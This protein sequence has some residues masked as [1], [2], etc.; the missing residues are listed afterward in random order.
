MIAKQDLR[1][2]LRK[3]PPPTEAL[4]DPERALLS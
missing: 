2:R 4:T 3:E 1:R